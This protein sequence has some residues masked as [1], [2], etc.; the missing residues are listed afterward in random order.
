MVSSTHTARMDEILL[1]VLSDFLFPVLLY[2]S[3]VLLE[4]NIHLRYFIC[5]PIFLKSFEKFCLTEFSTE[6][7]EFWVAC[8]DFARLEK[9]EDLDQKAKEIKAKFVG[10]SA[11]SQVNLKGSVEAK[12]LKALKETPLR[13]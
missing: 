8:R 11:P 13:P 4:Y 12:L 1:S 6:N 9:Q 7:I 3:A 10:N 2:C 5:N